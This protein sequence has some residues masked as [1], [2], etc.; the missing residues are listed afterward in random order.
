M[1]QGERW[2]TGFQIRDDLLQLG[3]FIRPHDYKLKAK[4]S[5]LD[6][7][8]LRLVNAQWPAKTRGVDPAFE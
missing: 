4:R 3:P 8:N 7:S 5:A 2:L 1:E 6:P